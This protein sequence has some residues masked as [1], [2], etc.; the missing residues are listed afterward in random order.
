MY[1][2]LLEYQVAQLSNIKLNYKEIKTFR[3][4]EAN[5]QVVWWI[6]DL[7]ADLKKVGYSG[8]LKSEQ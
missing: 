4:G 8:N 5:Q 7:E 2:I 1:N 3:L 6:V